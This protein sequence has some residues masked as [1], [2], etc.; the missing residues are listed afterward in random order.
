MLYGY[1]R[2]STIDQVLS[3]ERSALRAAGCEVVRA[4]K[5]SGASNAGREELR[6]VFDCA[7]LRV[8]KTRYARAAPSLSSPQAEDEREGA[9]GTLRFAQPRSAFPKFESYQAALSSLKDQV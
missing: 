9:A 7:V 3:I 1:A 6:T 2:V 8:G 5:C 4:E